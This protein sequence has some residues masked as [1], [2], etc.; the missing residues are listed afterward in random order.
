MTRPGLTGTHRRV[1]LNTIT[2][3]DGYYPNEKRIICFC[4]SE[5][6]LEFYGEGK[7]R[8]HFRKIPSIKSGRLKEIPLWQGYYRWLALMICL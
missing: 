6:T 3:L 1:L 7:S 2:F 5:S 4:P 8:I